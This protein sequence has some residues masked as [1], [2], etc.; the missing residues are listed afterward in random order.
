MSV[1]DLIISQI[2]PDQKDRDRVAQFG[3]YKRGMRNW[4]YG[5]GTPISSNATKQA[6]LITCPIKLVKRAKATVAK[7]GTR[8]YH[9]FQSGHPVLE[10]VWKPFRQRLHSLG[11]TRQQ[12]QEIES[13]GEE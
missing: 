10:N 7:W 11:F 9:G 6:K 3:F 2:Q 12:I 13:Y 4:F 5:D 8:D 1:Q